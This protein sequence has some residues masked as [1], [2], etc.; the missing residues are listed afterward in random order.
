MRPARGPAVSAHGEPGRPATVEQVKYSDY[1]SGTPA[2]SVQRDEPCPEANPATHATRRQRGAADPVLVTLLVLLLASVSAFLSGL[3]PYPYG[4]I[5]LAALVSA[6]LLW[7]RGDR[8]N[9]TATRAKGP[10]P[11]RDGS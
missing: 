1:C 2:M 9:G 4:L 11:P 5:V 8:R 3:I 10:R 7:L 6:R